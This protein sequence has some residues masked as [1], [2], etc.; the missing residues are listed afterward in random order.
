MRELRKISFYRLVRAVFKKEFFHIFRDLRTLLIIL[1]LPMIQLF[2]YGYALTFDVREIPLAV[3]DR[4]H[5][6]L[7][8]DLA[9]AF[10]RSGYFKVVA[11]PLESDFQFRLDRGEIG[12]A[13]IIPGGFQKKVKKGEKTS[14][15]MIIDGSDPVIG[16]V[17]YGYSLAIISNFSSLLAH[18]YLE[19]QGWRLKEAFLPLEGRLR[20]W[21]NPELKSVNYIVPGLIAL[22]MLTL[23]TIE[24]A[25]SI[26]KEKENGTWENLLIS[27]LSSLDLILGKTLPYLLLAFLS[28]LLV[29]AV[30]VFWF[31]VPFR[32]SFFLFLLS[33]TVYLIGTI[34]MGLFISAL[35]DSQQV[36]TLVA[37]L[38]TFI[39]SMMLSGFIFPIRSMPQILQFLTYFIPARYFLVILRGIFLKGISFDFLWPDFL[40]LVLFDLAI[41]TLAS[42]LIRRDLG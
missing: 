4:D 2:M 1:F 40:S 32:G 36:A 5:S 15:Q 18:S 17:A 6:A 30:G 21:Y 13:L 19:S 12:A 27:P 22:L 28:A 24:T 20:V 7:S 23:G 14:V 8:R 3:Y 38:S 29:T 34:G 9:S 16:R 10:T 33:L 11:Y 35:T 25:T 26:V 42:L 37:F 41:L 31:G 39:P